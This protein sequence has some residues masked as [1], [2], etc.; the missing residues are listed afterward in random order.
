[1]AKKSSRSI[2][3][4]DV[5]ERAGVSIASVSRVM[6]E[7][8]GSV[9]VET[10]Q[11]VIKA[12]EDLN[13][14]P[15]HIGRALRARTTN[16]YAL[17]ISNIQNNFYAAVAWELER[18]FNERGVAM[19]LYTSNENP[20]IQDRCLEDIRS[21]QVSGIFLLCAVDSPR[22]RDLVGREPVV[23][24]NRRVP[25]VGDTSFIGIDDRAAARDLATAA[26]RRRPGP[27][28]LIHGP[29]T[30]D[31]SARR[32]RGML[33]ICAQ[34]GTPVPPQHRREARL[35]MESG[36]DAAVS[37]LD[38][39]SFST[40]LC[41]NDQ[42]AYG[43]Y[44][45]CRELGLRVP[46][47]LPIYGFDDNPLNEWLASWLNTVR[48]PHLDLA[49]AAIEEMESLRASRAPREVILPYQLVLRT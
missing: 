20:E 36:Y 38:G 34:F 48:V 1:M 6:N 47:D 24:I 41:G 42:I 30:S 49:K 5:A 16:T 46:D 2:S 13:Y 8:S 10:R 19:L 3:I 18:L 7:G 22:L 11:K 14:S 40:L 9:S 37:L 4:K 44:R 12:V 28:A 25:A 39:Q 31:T 27:V 45:R 17:I 26:L 32:M 15:N 21:R 43:A 23:F 29:L 35:S 33:D